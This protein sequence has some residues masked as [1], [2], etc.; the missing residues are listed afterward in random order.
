VSELVRE[1]TGHPRVAFCNTGSEA[2]LGAVRAARTVTGRS[3]IALFRD[4]YHGIF[5]EV[6]VRGGTQQRS[7]P[8]APGIP[9]S[10]VEAVLVLDYGEESALATLRER[11]D[12]I[13]AVLVEPVQSR[14]LDLQPREFL[15]RLRQLATETG[16]ALIFDEVITGF[17]VDLGGAQEH[18]GVRA[19]LATYGKV[20]GGGLPIGV[21][22]GAPRFLDALDGGPWSFGDDSFPAVGVTYFAGTFVRHPL[23]LT[24]A[25]A[26]LTHLR[27]EGNG[28]QERVNALASHCVAELERVCRELGAPVRFAHFSSAFQ[29]SFTTEAPF[30]GL[31]FPLL[32]ERGIH[33]FEGRTWFLTAAHTEADVAFLVDA[34]HDAVGA[35]LDVGLLPRAAS[36]NGAHA[37]AASSGPGAP[38][39]PDARLGRDPA[40]RPGWYRPDPD[41]PGKFLRIGD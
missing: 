8:A 21:I 12:S 2:V 17:R 11:A 4:S 40:G 41:R 22:A 20:V 14:R 35:L 6:I 3:T 7:V 31:L 25:K 27:A 38:P 18:F 24:A 10:A 19:D 36:G 5:D 32:R 29:P 15:H 16:I 30:G 26:V 28:L 39:T 13:A 34:F 33:M 1:L 9:R 37:S 23:A